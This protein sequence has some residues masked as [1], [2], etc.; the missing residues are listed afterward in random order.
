MEP[1]WDTCRYCPPANVG[2]TRVIKPTRVVSPLR[3][4]G[5]DPAGVKKKPM[6]T[7]QLYSESKKESSAELLGWLVVTQGKEQ[8]RDYRITG[9]HFVLGRD[10]DCDIV[11]DDGHVSSRHASLRFREGKM[12]LTDLDSSNGTFV[13][14]DQISR[15]DLE[16]NAEIKIG[17]TVLKFRKF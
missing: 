7:T 3:V 4:A 16:D 15:V 12:V 14:G 2:A 6:G 1:D 10:K 8:W 9:G 17:D 5:I 13:N 11:I